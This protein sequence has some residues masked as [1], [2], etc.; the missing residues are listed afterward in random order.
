[1]RVSIG[2]VS[3]FF[4]TEGCALVPDGDVMAQ[5]PT[6]VLLHGGPGAD[7][8]LF[9]PEF[10]DLADVAQLVYLDQR[11]SGRSDIG[12]PSTWTWTQWAD[13]VAAFCR[14]LDIT[15]PIL[16]GSSSGGLVAMICAARRPDLVAGL[17]LDSALGVP[18]SLDETLDVFE[19]RG[20]PIA[21]D[22]AQHYLTGDTS[23]EAAEAW[24][25][26]GLP[27]YGNTAATAD[28]AH[29][30]AR[31]RMN[32]EVLTHFRRGN[33]GST[34]PAEHLTAIGCPTLIL[35]GEHDPVS[36]AAAAHRLAVALTNAPVTIETI[37][38]IGHGVFRQATQQ[39][40]THVRRF[41]GHTLGSESRPNS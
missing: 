36:P 33:C 29:R 24:Q 30:R 18:T 2:D 4:D 28:L 34:D 27:L 35:A 7:H 6:L 8:S 12:T 25:Q 32:D 16:V 23:L 13:D 26:H 3:L 22:A 14:T 31:A 21:R 15:R 20:G 39:T 5:R 17:I 19:S 1:M 40:F 37:A 9:K 41:L 10:S 38:D 11:G